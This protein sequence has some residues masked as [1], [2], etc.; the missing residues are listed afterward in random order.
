MLAAVL[1]AVARPYKKVSHNVMDV[2]FLIYAIC[3][4]IQSEVK[5]IEI[6]TTSFYTSSLFFAICPHYLPCV[7]ITLC[8]AWAARGQMIALGLEYI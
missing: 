6:M 1:F 3:F 8:C 2:V 5:C 7:F 4:N